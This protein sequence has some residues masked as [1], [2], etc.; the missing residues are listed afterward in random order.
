MGILPNSRT[1]ERKRKRK[2]HP[3]T[4]GLFPSLT[5]RL[6]LL[7]C[8]AADSPPPASGA[9]PAPSI[10]FHRPA[11]NRRRHPHPGPKRRRS[12]RS[13]PNR[14]RRPRPAPNRR[15]RPHSATNRARRRRLPASPL[16]KDTTRLRRALLPPPPPSG[17]P[18]WTEHLDL[19]TPG[20][21]GARA[22]LLLPWPPHPLVPIGHA[23]CPPPPPVAQFT[24]RSKPSPP[25]PRCEGKK[26]PNS[27]EPRT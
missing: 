18:P 25:P 26:I 16:P 12:P 21:T 17:A 15:R 14:G 23:W 10:C 4:P 6:P 22:L 5:S 27:G 8:I 19:V 9:P 1:V 3:L 24:G 7:P 13:A 11:P 20:T 2:G